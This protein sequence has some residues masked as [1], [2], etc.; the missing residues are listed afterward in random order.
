MVVSCLTSFLSYYVEV[1][2]IFALNGID[3]LIQRVGLQQ[4]LVGVKSRYHTIVH[5]QYAVTVANAENALSDDD[6]CHVRQLSV[7]SLSY[8]GICSS[9]AG[10]GR[11]VEYQYLWFFQ[12]CP[13]Y[14]ESL[15]LASTHVST[16]LFY[17][18][19][20][21]LWHLVDELIG[22]SQL[23]GPLAFCQ[24]G[25]TISPAQIVEDSPAE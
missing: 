20:I 11:V 1:A 3:L 15:L 13:G 9:V 17:S 24:R 10:R 14:T 16:T 4:L 21:S 2:H 6:F 7:Q 23:A 5:H 19:V 12:Q 22:T 8:L 25:I 18:A